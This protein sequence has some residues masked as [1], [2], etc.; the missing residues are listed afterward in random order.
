MISAMKNCMNLN[1]PIGAIIMF[2]ISSSI[3]ILVEYQQHLKGMKG[4]RKKKDQTAKANIPNVLRS[5]V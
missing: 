5:S 3:N 4:K 1:F 2:Q